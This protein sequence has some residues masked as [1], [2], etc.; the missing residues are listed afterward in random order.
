[1]IEKKALEAMNGM[2]ALGAVYGSA[3]EA[4]LEFA[5]VLQQTLGCLRKEPSTSDGLPNVVLMELRTQQNPMKFDFVFFLSGIH[6]F[7][8]SWVY[9]FWK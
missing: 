3:K 1:M 5:C 8:L 6:L 2:P 7:H 9:N 4:S